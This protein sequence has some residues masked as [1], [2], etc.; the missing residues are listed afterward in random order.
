MRSPV[1]KVHKSLFDGFELGADSDVSGHALSNDVVGFAA[2]RT[3]AAE[4]CL[5]QLPMSMF[6]TWSDHTKMVISQNSTK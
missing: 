1:R 5:D 4:F 3:V 2:S 6:Y